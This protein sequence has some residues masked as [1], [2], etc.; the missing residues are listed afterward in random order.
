MF[1][2]RDALVFKFEAD[3]DSGGSSPLGDA[4]ENSFLEDDL[5]VT[6]G[7]EA[8]AKGLDDSNP[9]F[10]E[11]WKSVALCSRNYHPNGTEVTT[12]KDSWSRGLDGAISFHCFST[13]SRSETSIQCTALPT[14]HAT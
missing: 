9:T 10:D 14:D 5:L 2:R 3:K 12:S 7:I 4:E 11:I 13:I 1:R 6:R 8:G